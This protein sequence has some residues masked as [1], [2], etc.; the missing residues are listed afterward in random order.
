MRAATG[1]R[2]IGDD[3]AVID[4][5]TGPRAQLTAVLWEPPDISG[6]PRSAI[7][8]T[9]DLLADL[10]AAGVRSLAFVRSRRAAETVAM[11]AQ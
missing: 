6:A 4:V 7:A 11:L 8:E 1:A 10:T 9:A 5:D 2:L 3:L